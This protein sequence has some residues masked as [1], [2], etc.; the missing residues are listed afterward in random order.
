MTERCYHLIC[1]ITRTFGYESNLIQCRD[2]GKEFRENTNDYG[3]AVGSFGHPEHVMY[4][5]DF[6]GTAINNIYREYVE[7]KREKT[8]ED[9]GK[10]K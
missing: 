10:V 8:K 7:L 5:G 3:I 9:E 6:S 4:Y 2:C 1:D